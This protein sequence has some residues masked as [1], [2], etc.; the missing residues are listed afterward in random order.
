MKRLVRFIITLVAAVAVL[1]F[2]PLYIERTMIRSWR[3]DH[4]GDVIEWGW[5]LRTLS[6]YWSDYNYFRPEQRPA[7]WLAVNVALAITYALTI[8]LGLDQLL[9][10]RKRRREAR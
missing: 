5:A 8:A 10:W 3:T 2:V 6:G 9:M 1:P 4:A 7:F